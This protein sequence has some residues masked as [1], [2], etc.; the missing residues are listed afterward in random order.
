MIRPACI[1]FGKTALLTVLAT[2]LLTACG[3]VGDAG[4]V[5]EAND[6]AIECRTDEALAAAEQ[7]LE[8]GGV[9]MHIAG[10]IR[11]AIL[12]DAGRDAEATQALADYLAMPDSVEMTEDDIEEA[13]GEFI[14]GF[15]EERIDK[16]GS[17]DCP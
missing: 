15:R 10:M 13:V 6:L 1:P 2:G 7:A 17:A 5:R 8:A 3:A 16:T 9:S 11:V 12:R 4:A 14:R